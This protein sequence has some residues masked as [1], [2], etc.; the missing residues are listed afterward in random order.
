MALTFAASVRVTTRHSA[1][2]QECAGCTALA[3]LAPDETH[4]RDCRTAPVRRRRQS[5]A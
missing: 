2:W 4:C 3:P 1:V 5:A